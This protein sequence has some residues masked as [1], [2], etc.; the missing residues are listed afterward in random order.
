MRD[1]RART[2]PRR[3]ARARPA[4][5]HSRT[6]AQPAVGLARRFKL[7]R[8]AQGATYTRAIGLLD[9]IKRLLTG[10]KADAEVAVEDQEPVSTPEAEDGRETSTN[11]Q[12]SGATDEPWPGND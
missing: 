7:H 1:A 4:Q 10:A 11:A 8:H 5:G 3:S 12:T 2:V 9:G 6:L